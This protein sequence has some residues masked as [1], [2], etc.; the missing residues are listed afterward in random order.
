MAQKGVYK[1]GQYWWIRYTVGKRL[2]RESTKQSNYREACRMLE[3]R[4]TDISRG[5]YDLNKKEAPFFEEYADYFLEY[6][7]KPNKRS[8]KRDVRSIKYLKAAF[9]G[10]R[11]SGITREHINKYK[12]D[13]MRETTMRKAP[14]ARATVNREL[15]VLR[16]MFNMAKEEGKVEHNPVSGRGILFRENNKVERI[17]SRK[18]EAH[19]YDVCL[20][21]LPKRIYWIIR[22]GFQTGMRIGELLALEWRD[23]DLV[24]RR[25]TVRAEIAKSGKARAIPI[26]KNLTTMLKEVKKET[27]KAGEYVFSGQ[28]PIKSIRTS[29]A[30]AKGLAEIDPRFRFHDIRHTVA[31]RL[32]TENGVDLV[33]VASILGHADLKMLERYAHTRRDIELNAMETLNDTGIESQLHKKCTIEEK[34]EETESRKLVQFA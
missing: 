19:L 27:K 2:I 26:N 3:A 7:A 15:A 32:I 1:R 31:S 25:I 10:Q 21:H 28:K 4:K 8:W 11:L 16:T 30:K 22:A 33:T 20:E 29:F 13:R 14:P 12:V 18:E 6:Y 17:L 34:E 23:V 9:S 24:N 5:A